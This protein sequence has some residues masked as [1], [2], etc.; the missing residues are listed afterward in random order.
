M[1]VVLSNALR[2]HDADVQRARDNNIRKLSQGV[3]PPLTVGDKAFLKA[4]G[5]AHE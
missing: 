3:L 1:Q 4:M 5:I 2:A